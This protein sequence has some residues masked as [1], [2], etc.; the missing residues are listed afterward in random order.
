MQNCKWVHKLLPERHCPPVLT[1]LDDDLEAQIE[2]V[3]WAPWNC[4]L[5]C[6]G[7]GRASPPSFLA[8]VQPVLGGLCVP[9]CGRPHLLAEAWSSCRDHS[10]ASPW[11]F[12]CRCGTMMRDRG[13][14]GG[15]GNAVQ[16]L[17]AGNP[18]VQQ[19]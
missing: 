11:V 15:L 8:Q 3:C 12:V 9:T 13:L 18:G 2:L 17:V 7:V 5:G 14:L 10:V 6:G 16:A 19:S 4:G 1:D